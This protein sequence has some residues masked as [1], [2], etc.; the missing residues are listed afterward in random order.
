MRLLF[1]TIT[2]LG[3]GLF[4]LIGSAFAEPDLVYIRIETS[5]GD[6]DVVL[7]QQKAPLTTANF[8]SYAKSGYYDQLIFH[9]VVRDTLIQ[10]GGLTKRLTY[11]ATVDPVPSESANGLKNE[12]GTIAMARFDDPDSATSQFYINLKDN[13]FLDRTGDVFKMDAGY[14]VFGR[15][16]AGMGVADA[17]GEVSTGPASG[18][19]FGGIALAE[20]VPMD[21]I[22][23]LSARPITEPDVGATSV[24]PAE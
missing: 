6:I 15:V 10:G 13:P 5:L 19:R 8:L 3:V 14:T 20:E 7:D 9:R 17:I 22:F 23:I 24:N 12:R 18:E 1:A 21:P 11:R 2:S 4:A 16:V